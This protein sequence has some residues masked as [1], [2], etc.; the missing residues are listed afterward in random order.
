MLSIQTI[1]RVAARHRLS[2]SDEAAALVLVDSFEG[3]TVGAALVD[4]LNAY[5]GVSDRTIKAILNDPEA[6]AIV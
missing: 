3:E 1:K 5:E 2:L 6:G 4:F